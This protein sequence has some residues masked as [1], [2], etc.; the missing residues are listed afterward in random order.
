M[1]S[2]ILPDYRQRAIRVEVFKDTMARI[3]A[4][5]DLRQA[6]SK[7]IETQRFIA[8]GAAIA[9][10]EPAY[11]EPAAVTVTKNRSFEAAHPYAEQG[12]RTAVLNFA[13]S[14]SPG[15]GVTRGAGAQE[16]SLCRVS[17]LYP[18]L[19]DERMW[20]LF[21]APHRR[22]KNPLH[23]DDIIYTKDVLVLKDDD[24]RPLEKPFAVD[25]VTCAA[26]NLREDASNAYNPDDGE[27]AEIDPAELL[28]LHEKRGRRILAV[29]AAN[30]AQA[31][32]LGAFG[33]GAFR[34]DPAIVARAYANVLPAFRRH[35]RT[36]EF[37][38]FCGPRSTRNY[39]AFRAIG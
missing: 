37:A 33:C 19:K 5:G 20:N 21:Y 16:E 27:R 39:E 2:E 12:L 34:N 3:E 28:A 32:V 14:T 38:V 36:I 4:V 11:A 17:T 30:G 24:Y 35:F 26:P 18:C 6:V 10:P 1:K 22:A 9:L 8:E 13:S 23:N 7:S 15:G 25:V 29:A 31:L